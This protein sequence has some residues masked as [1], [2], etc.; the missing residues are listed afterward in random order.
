MSAQDTDTP[1]SDDPETTSGTALAEEGDGVPFKMTLS[2]DIQNA[3]PCKKHVRVQ[4]P[5]SDL[6]HFYNEAVK[7]LNG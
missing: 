5:R 6:D 3:G 7:D 4:V 1:Q 2:V